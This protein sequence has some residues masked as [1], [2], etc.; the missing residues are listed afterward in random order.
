VADTIL[1]K[2]RGIG[3]PATDILFGVG[4]CVCSHCYEVR[5]DVAGLFSEAYAGAVLHREGEIT[6]D[7]SRII[8]MQ[9]LSAGVKGE[10]ITLSGLC[11][12][13]DKELFYSHRRDGLNAGAMG[14]FICLDR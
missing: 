4:T 3:I 9:L 6:L 11:T 1:E 14:S 5:Q 2:M 12:Y 13:C 10:H 8:S 7:L